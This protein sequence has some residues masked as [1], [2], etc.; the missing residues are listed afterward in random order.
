M[1][2][3]RDDDIKNLN[4]STINGVS[5]NDIITKFNSIATPI[6]AGVNPAGM[7]LVPV[8]NKLFVANN[9]NYGLT[10]EDSVTV[11]NTKTL[12]PITTIYDNSFY[13]PYTVTI[14]TDKTKAYVT[15]SSGSTITVINTSTNAVTNII[16]GFDG[17]S[18][19]V[20][21]SLTNIGYVNN[22]GASSPIFIGTIS[23]NILTVN[24][25]TQGKI[26]SNIEITS[27]AQFVG[28][29]SG[30]T[31]TVTSMISG[32]IGIE[33]IISGSGIT[34]TGINQYGTGN[35]G[36]GTYVIYGSQNVGSTTIT[37]TAGAGSNIMPGTFITAY[38]TG[39][40]GTGTYSVSIN[41]EVS[42]EYPINMGGLVV[43]VGSGN[44]NKVSVVNLNT[45]TIIQNIIVGLA[46][47][48]LAIT[49]DIPRFVYTANYVDGNPNTATLTKIQTSN[50][51]VIQT[52]GPFSPNGFSGPFAIAINNTNTRAYVT[53]F[54]SNNF[55]PYGTT[56]SVVDL[57]TN[58]I[59]ATIP[60]GIQPSGLAIVPGDN[61]AY[62]SN[63]NTLYQSPVQFQ[64]LTA[65]EG[66]LNVLDLKTNT[67]VGKTIK[68]GQ[69]PANIVISQSGDLVF[70]SNYTSNTVSVITNT[71]F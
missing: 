65:G 4:V 10:N 64:N 25:V 47:A 48:T 15:N 45:N 7:A 71:Y 16:N 61:Y 13:G 18:G 29:I 28:S 30:N 8:L 27:S 59:I 38:L 70:V 1:E 33:S 67:V 17:P 52:L 51:T 14:S 37:S 34:P 20:I 21:N 53:N 2:I 41:Q 9:N 66:T 55:Q 19:M 44:G 3:I 32:V 57:N 24:S 68:V 43:G 31:L 56:I 49:S 23:G 5:V 26:I 35:G 54:G 11:I 46:P 22:Y 60:V 42:N 62:I 58:L 63:Y 69:S 39:T 36:V 12:L 40:G 6:C 50:N